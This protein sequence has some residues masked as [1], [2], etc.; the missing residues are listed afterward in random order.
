MSGKRE[1]GKDNS[2]MKI[3]EETKRNID[4]EWP[5]WKKSITPFQ[6]TASTITLKSTYKKEVTPSKKK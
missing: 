6:T 2:F 3:F 4:S 5:E 1:R